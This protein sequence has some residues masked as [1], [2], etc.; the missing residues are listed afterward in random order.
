[1]LDKVFLHKIP[2]GL[3]KNSK[4]PAINID[5]L[6]EFGSTRIVTEFKPCKNINS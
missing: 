6:R 2:S 3:S 4:T 1:M 5:S